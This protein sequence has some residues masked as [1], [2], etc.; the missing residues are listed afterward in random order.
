MDDMGNFYNSHDELLVFQAAHKTEYYQANADF[1]D[2]GGYGGST[3]DE[4]M[5]GDA[6]TVGIMQDAEEGLAFLDRIIDNNNAGKSRTSGTNSNSN[7]KTRG[8]NSNS[9]NS[10]ATATM[11]M[12]AMRQDVAVD[13]GAGV[14]RVSKMVLLKRYDH[15]RLVEGNAAFMKRSRG[16]LGK[17]RAARCSFTTCFLQDLDVNDIILEWG[18]SGA[19]AGVSS[20][21]KSNN[22]GNDNS[23]DAGSVDLM[24]VQW[25]LQYLTDV[26]VVE[27]LKKLAKGLRPLVGVLV[28][29]ENR[30]YGTAR[31]DR[32]QMDTPTGASAQGRYD[33]T[34]SDAHHRLLFHMAGLQVDFSEMGTE[35]SSFALKLML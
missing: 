4:V 35:T 9:N 27:C 22:N 32:F 18:G 20:S 19:S 5:V 6:D 10:T 24:W 34:R 17:K 14:G 12:P 33:I 25:T 11:T 31:P 30:P 2:N 21:S 16:Y 13:L 3:D 8:N 15:V 26:D 23:G 1:W 29:K 7:H 28:V